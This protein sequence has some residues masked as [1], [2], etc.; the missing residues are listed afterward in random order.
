VDAFLELWYNG[1]RVWTDNAAGGGTN[2]R[3]VFKPEPGKFGFY[4]IR[5]STFAQFQSGTYTLSIRIQ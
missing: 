5:A 1:Q 3:I 4:E 2:A